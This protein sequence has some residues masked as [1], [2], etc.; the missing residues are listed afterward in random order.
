M[1]AAVALE[2]LRVHFKGRARELQAVRRSD[3]H[4][5]RRQPAAAEI[6]N[7]CG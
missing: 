6:V 2:W 3:R 5:L 4:G 7:R 1:D